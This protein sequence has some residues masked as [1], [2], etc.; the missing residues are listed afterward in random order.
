MTT[1]TSSGADSAL[2]LAITGMHCASCSSRIE[3]ALGQL[4]G[5]ARATVNLATAEGAVIFA[6]DAEPPRVTETV[7]ERIRE[8]G[9]DA[10]PVREDADVGETWREEQQATRDRLTAMRRQ[11]APMFLFSVPLFIISMGHMVGMPLP[12][13]LDPMTAPLNFALAQ[14]ILTLPVIGLGRQ[15]YKSGVAG[16][17]HGSPNMDSLVAV[18]TGAAFLYSL[19]NTVEILFGVEPHLRS[20]DLYYESCAILLTMISLGQY[21]EALSR[22]R[23]SDA[24][25]SLMQ[26]APSTALLLEDGRPREVPVDQ[27]RPGDLLLVRAGSRIPVDGVVTEGTSSVDLSLLTGESMPAPVEAGDALTGG[28][29]NG[30]GVLT[31]R[32]VHVG[33]DTMLS[34][35]IRLVREAQGS[36]APIANLADRVSFYFV[37]AVI[38]LA[39]LAAGAWMVFGHEP[40]SVALRIFV[41]VLVIACPCAMGL[42]TPTSIM[43]ATG[44]GAQ[45][46]VLVK[47]GA[48]L[49]QAGKLTALAVDK[50]GT[51]TTGKPR[52]VEIAPL[53]GM[54]TDT[55]LAL[56]AALES[57][58]EHPLAH[59]VLEAAQDRGMT[60]A[61]AGDT[62][63]FP[64]LGIRG[65]VP[66]AGVVC[67]AS[68][69]NL[70]LMERLNIALPDDGTL[71]GRLDALADQGKTP[72]LL[73]VDGVAQGI[74]AL[75]DVLRPESAS[76]VRRLKE[77][78]LRVVMLSGDNERTARA[79][80]REAGID[81]VVA[82]VLPHQKEETVARLQAEGYCVGM[83]GDGI[84]DAPALARADVG[85]AVGTGVDVSVEAGDIIL[86][87]NGMEA[88]LTALALSR[89][90]MRNI[91]QNLF[92][93]FG[94]NV[95]GLPVAAGVLHIFGGPTLSPMLAGTAMALSST[96]VVT[97]AL[98]LRWFSVGEKGGTKHLRVGRKFST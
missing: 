72:L 38:S 39:V 47:N 43:V 64:G 73:A 85:M 59:A 88:V 9:F 94:Y 52:L 69:G 62:E 21:M 96:S 28:S 18:G 11:L 70:A 55:L 14:L 10:T 95:L 45:L 29:I 15:F 75:A 56:A 48:A 31:M 60:P 6:P 35:I 92:W 1:P 81:E 41:A 19:W 42:A 57:R 32:V 4:P 76:V 33:Q 51:L 24:I 30:A 63:V 23:T 61:Q 87:R 54:D 40:L 68:L 17:L 16:L 49:E 71:R 74:L 86:M 84:N 8:L 89:A 50:T 80:A 25:G 34:R 27:V 26:L 78:G 46:G 20:M 66:H 5:V 44:R 83:V 77:A 3:R 53:G 67:T 98:R 58:S 90:T 22:Q 2:H 82:G 12:S 93:A 91:R 36:K 65:V 37:P 13:R 97:N 7:L 79:I